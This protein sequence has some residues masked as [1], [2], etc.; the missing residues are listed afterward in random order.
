MLM[1]IC[2]LV[3]GRFWLLRIGL[4]LGMGHDVDQEE[5][6]DADKEFDGGCDRNDWFATVM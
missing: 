4:G 2:C 5:K 3:L 1:G 6:S